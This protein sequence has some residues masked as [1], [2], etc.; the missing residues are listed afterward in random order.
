M[1]SKRLLSLSLSLGGAS[2][3]QCDRRDD[4]V[5]DVCEVLAQC[6]RYKDSYIDNWKECE[7]DV[8]DAVQDG[9]ITRA[10]LT[11]CSKCLAHH[12]YQEQRQS[13]CDEPPCEN[14]ESLLRE[15]DCDEACSEVDFAL[16]ARTSLAM[17]KAM[18]L[19]VDDSCGIPNVNAC[20]AALTTLYEDLSGLGGNGGEDSGGRAG[21]KGRNLTLNESLELDATVEACWA[22]TQSVRKTF[23][24]GPGINRP[25]RCA[26]LVDTC[27]A[28]CSLV[29]PASL[30][31]APAQIALKACDLEDRCVVKEQESGMGAAGEPPEPRLNC[32]L[33]CT[34]GCAK[35]GGGTGG[36]GT[37]GK[38]GSPNCFEDRVVCNQS[39]SM[40]RAQLC[41]DCA[42]D[43]DCSVVA[44]QCRVACEGE[45]Q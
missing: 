40:T 7:R 28:T 34:D 1:L 12:E 9:R 3:L 26:K 20:K 32:V 17:R 37:A 43:Q 22:C 33:G 14:C 29:R 18:C 41:L 24:G 4:R 35:G 5:T 10:G 11:G 27:D 16:R 8:K 2:L 13:E 44:T 38:P 23:T 45:A 42:G 25:E 30:V 31:L 19:V 21:L 15:R 6:A 39:D 36:A